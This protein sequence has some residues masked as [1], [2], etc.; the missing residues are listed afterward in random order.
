M[1]FSQ[2][3]RD[4]MKIAIDEAKMALE[5]GNFPVGAVL[6]VDGKVVGQGRNSIRSSKDWASH[7]EMSLLFKNSSLIKESVKNNNSVVTLYTSLEPCL[8]CFGTLVLH[9]ITRVVYACDDPFTGGT[10]ISVTELPVGYKRM[11][12]RLIGGLM[13]EDS[14]KLVMAFMENENDPK[15]KEALELYLKS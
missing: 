12:P 14:R 10:N 11:W 7:A 8:M 2:E 15:W 3:D 4:F 13:K 6:V 9:R 5:E 1:E